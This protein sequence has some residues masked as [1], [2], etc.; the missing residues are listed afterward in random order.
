MD[1]AKP[2]F[3]SFNSIQSLGDGQGLGSD[4][5][6]GPLGEMTDNGNGINNDNFPY[7]GKPF[8]NCDLDSA[9]PLT[10]SHTIWTA[11]SPNGQPRSPIVSFLLA[12]LIMIAQ[13]FIPHKQKGHYS[14]V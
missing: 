14:Q 4:R 10:E 1:D 2:S 5:S 3:T 8:L 6:P 9:L 7:V 11:S 13:R 12:T